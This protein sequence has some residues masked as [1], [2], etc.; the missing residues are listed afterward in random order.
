M[1]LIQIELKGCNHSFSCNYL[2]LSSF[3]WNLLVV[4]LYLDL[5]QTFRFVLMRISFCCILKNLDPVMLVFQCSLTIE[6]DPWLDEKV[7]GAW[8]ESIKFPYVSM[9]SMKSIK[10]YIACDGSVQSLINMWVICEALP[11]ERFLWQ[12]I[13]IVECVC[14]K[15]RKKFSWF[16]IIG[17]PTKFVLVE[18]TFHWS[19]Q[20][21]SMVIR[22]IV[23]RLLRY[24]QKVSLSEG[25]GG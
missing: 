6:W 19:L 23:K 1:C 9:E 3:T 25:C 22:A 18:V 24:D 12:G 14:S 13:A 11:W 17:A 20:L 8:S 2:S 10:K 4:S 15:Y 7:M 16:I 21:G 5:A